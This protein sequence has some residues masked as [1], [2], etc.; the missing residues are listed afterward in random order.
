MF[1]AGRGVWC[2]VDGDRRAFW[3]YA[4]YLGWQ[5]SD[6]DGKIG[7]A[8]KRIGWR[9]AAIKRCEKTSPHCSGN[10]ELCISLHLHDGEHLS[11][12][13]WYR[14]STEYHA[15]TAEQS[16]HRRRT[17]NGTHATGRYVDC[18]IFA[19]QRKC[20]FRF[21]WQYEFDCHRADCM[22]RSVGSGCSL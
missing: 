10:G 5:W 3:P 2:H 22:C 18:A 9:Y 11:K 19:P 4:V 1:G 13:V 20:I 21:D 16:R 17:R 7:E 8:V 12:S 15:G 14:T 6:S